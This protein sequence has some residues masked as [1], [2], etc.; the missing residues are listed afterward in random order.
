M[1]LARCFQQYGPTEEAL[2][3]YEG[4]RYKRTAAITKYSRYYGTIG[5]STIP[6]KFLFSLIPEPALQRL[7]RIVFDYDATT[8]KV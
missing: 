3:K 4:C 6:L 8:T 1:I 5:Q 2:R 7:M